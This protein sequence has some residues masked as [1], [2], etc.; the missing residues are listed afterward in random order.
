M[1]AGMSAPRRQHLHAAVADAIARL[2]PD[3]V[4]E[5]GGDIAIHRMKA[6]SFAA[7]ERATV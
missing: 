1:L 3:A 7:E 6:G 5:R 2:H 4:N